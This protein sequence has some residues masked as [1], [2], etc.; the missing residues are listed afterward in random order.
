[1]TTTQQ[2]PAAPPTAP[3]PHP[4]MARS[5]RRVILVV[6]SVVAALIVLALALPTASQLLQTTER[7][8]HPLPADLTSLRVENS[9]GDITVRATGPGEEPGAVATLRSGLTDAGVDV[10]TSGGTTTLTDSCGGWWWENC[11]VQ[12]EVL[13][14]ADTAVTVDTAV[15]EV[16]VTDLTGTLSL[17]SDVGSITGTALKSEDVTARSA[18]GDIDLSLTVAPTRVRASS[19]T[20]DVAVTLPD[21]DTTYLV[22]TS[23]SVGE[24]RNTVGSDGTSPRTVD[25]RTSV[26]DIVLR[27]AG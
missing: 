1:M 9:V 14:P 15:G 12:W 18:V 16:V 19:S 6:G 27:R 10:S 25:L 5:T 21:D 11:S 20:G 23:T 26:G 17:A 22:V 4:P 7:S 8:T 2:P 24:V 13:V 3:V